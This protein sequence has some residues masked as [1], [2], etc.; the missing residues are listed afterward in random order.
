MGRSVRDAAI[1]LGASA[2]VDARDP[3]TRGQTAYPDYTR[4]LDAN[5]FRGMRIGIARQYFNGS[6][7]VDKAINDSIALIKAAGAEIVDPV[8]FSKFEAWR[9][10]EIKVLLYEFK[11]D[12]NAYLANRGAKVKSL[13]DCIAFN[14]AH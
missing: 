1:L 13:A 2:G 4:F 3:A 7:A 6:P 12:L 14:R 8:K 10:S 9:D 11:T 5:A